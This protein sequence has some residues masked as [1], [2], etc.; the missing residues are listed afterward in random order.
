MRRVL[1][2]AG[3]TEATALADRLHGDGFDVVSSFA[4]VTR[5]R[6]PRP[7]RV[8]VGGFGGA[9]GLE[10]YLRDEAIDLVVDATHPFAAVMP[11]NAAEATR[12]A[13][14]P[15]LRLLR[16]AWTAVRGDQ[17]IDVANLDEAA[18]ALDSYRRVLLTVGRQSATAFARCDD[19]TFVVRSIEPIDDV[20]PGAMRVLDRGPF[21]L[22]A[23]RALLVEHRIDAIVSKNSGGSATEAKLTAARELGIPV[24]M[25]ARP[26]QPDVQQVADVDDAFGWVQEHSRP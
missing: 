2:L 9:D 12:R 14:V 20:L 19:I 3:T 11:F 8:R 1:V 7:G 18:A 25:V 6:Q 24:V 15:L 23:E 13:S 26:A 17:W 5:E 21:D 10:R 4:G 22:A 16:P